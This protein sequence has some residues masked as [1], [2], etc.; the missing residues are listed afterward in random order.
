MEVYI[1]YS[2]FINSSIRHS[3]IQFSI[4]FSR[5]F[6]AKVLAVALDPLILHFECKDNRGS[7]YIREQLVA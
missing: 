5:C 1:A 2:L 4:H 7:G 6:S 3:G